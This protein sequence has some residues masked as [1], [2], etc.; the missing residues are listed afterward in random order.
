MKKSLILENHHTDGNL[1]VHTSRSIKNRLEKLIG[2]NSKTF[3]G[4]VIVILSILISIFAPLIAP[5]D[6]IVGE[7]SLRLAPPGTPGHLLGLD[8]QG[9]DVLSRLIYGG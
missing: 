8:D 6:P 3:I 4:S 1:S 9:R 2:Q 5:Y 7:G